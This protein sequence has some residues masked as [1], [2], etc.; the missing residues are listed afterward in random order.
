LSYKSGEIKKPQGWSVFSHLTK[1]SAAFVQRDPL[2]RILKGLR[3]QVDI[4]TPNEPKKAHIYHFTFEAWCYAARGAVNHQ[5]LLS[6]DL[7]ERLYP[8]PRVQNYI[9][10]LRVFNRPFQDQDIKCFAA[11]RYASEL[12]RRINHKQPVD[13][14]ELMRHFG[15]A[16]DESRYDYPCL[17]RKLSDDQDKVLLTHMSE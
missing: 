17:C 7:S 12:I 13:T 1:P 9:Q 15:L 16:E 10:N 14:L 11:L 6:F 4:S 8:D 2:D 3:Y 5:T